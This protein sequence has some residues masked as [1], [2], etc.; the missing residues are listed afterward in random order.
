M[1]IVKNTDSLE[2]N[3]GGRIY[4]ATSQY[5]TEE[6]DRLRLLSDSVFIA[7]LTSGVAIVN[8]GNYDL[9]LRIALGL[10]R[11]DQVILNDYYTLVDEDGVLVGNGQIL[12]LNDDLWDLENPG[13]EEDS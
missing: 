13:E 7:D 10:L 11:N 4:P 12:N 9:T 8:D 5:E 1:I 6:V 3:W 2:K